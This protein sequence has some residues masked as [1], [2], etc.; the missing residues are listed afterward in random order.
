MGTLIWAHRGASGYAPENTLDAFELAIKQ[1]ADGVEL[2]VHL[3]ADGEIIVAHDETIDRCANGKGSIAAMTLAELKKFDFSKGMPGFEGTRVPT[4]AEVFA[5]L[6][7]TG[8]Q[9]NVELKTTIEFYPGIEKKCIDLARQMGMADR[10]W[11]SSFNHHSLLR[12]KQVDPA[13]PCGILYASTMVRPWD[14]AKG[15]GMEALHPMLT[16]LLI[17]GEV[18]DSHAT[19]IRVH[20]WTVNE[21]AHLELVAALGV[22]A[23]ITNYPDRALK[24]IGRG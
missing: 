13:F 6:R 10:V 7:P 16:E 23:I 20:T 15:L 21:Q 4:L 1:H 11:F 8:L 24:V 2:D 22:D 18:T 5:L 12:A 9:V 19:G 17:P 14:Y 3:S